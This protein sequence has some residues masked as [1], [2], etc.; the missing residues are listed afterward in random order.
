MI[1]WDSIVW[2]SKH[3][4]SLCLTASMSVWPFVIPPFVS[5]RSGAESHSW[6]NENKPLLWQ[7]SA[8]DGEVDAHS[9]GPAGRQLDFTLS[10][11]P[12]AVYSL[13]PLPKTSHEHLKID[14]I[15]LLRKYS[16][17][18]A[19]AAF[20]TLASL[21]SLKKQFTQKHLLKMSSPSGQPRFSWVCFFIGTAHQWILC[22]EWVPSEWESK[23][24]IKTSQ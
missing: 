5:S 17:S 16:C 22:S 2:H 6:E 24:L 3:S 21:T 18:P 11:C 10:V 13:L 20:W 14:P 8:A 9:E 7:A 23:Q 4:W 19:Y 1:S 15:M 12:T